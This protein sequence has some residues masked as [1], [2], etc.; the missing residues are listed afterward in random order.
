MASRCAPRWW[1]GLRRTQGRGGGEVAGAR[2][3]AGRGV[4][5]DE[6]GVLVAGVGTGEGASEPAFTSATRSGVI[7]P[8]TA[9]GPGRG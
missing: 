7:S 4:V 2:E 1:R 9:S 6:R 3:G 8:A 5:G